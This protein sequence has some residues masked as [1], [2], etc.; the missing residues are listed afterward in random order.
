MRYGVF[1]TL[2]GNLWELTRAAYEPWANGGCPWVN[3]VRA[4]LPLLK[5]LFMLS[6]GFTEALRLRKYLDLCDFGSTASLAL[7]GWVWIWAEK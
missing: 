3:G 5:V 6:L 1:E 4:C 2:P 7:I